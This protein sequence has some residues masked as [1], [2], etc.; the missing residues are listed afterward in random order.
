MDKF[1]ALMASL[2]NEIIDTWERGK[3]VILSI[4]GLIVVLEFRAIKEW[5]VAYLNSKLLKDTQAKDVKLETAEDTANK[6]ANALVAEAEALP[7]KEKPISSDWYK[8]D[9]K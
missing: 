6:Q 9:S 7:S 3:M 1:K 5:A 4:A 8:K 2:K